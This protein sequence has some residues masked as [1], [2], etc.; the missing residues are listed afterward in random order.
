MRF[1]ER[2]MFDFYD[3]DFCRSVERAGLRMG[4]WPIAITHTSVGQSGSPAWRGSL[5]TY[6]EKWVD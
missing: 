2:F 4:T 1:D 5:Q 6:R 3:L